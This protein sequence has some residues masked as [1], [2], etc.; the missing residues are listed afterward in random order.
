MFEES[1]V[2]LRNEIRNV[3]NC[4]RSNLET[5]DEYV[6]AIED[7][8]VPKIQIPSKEERLLSCGTSWQVH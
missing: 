1:K 5:E 4:L 6:E 2:E 3:F 8:K 7:L